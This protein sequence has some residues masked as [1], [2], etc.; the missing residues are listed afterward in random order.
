MS[1]CLSMWPLI[2]SAAGHDR[3]MR[4]VSIEPLWPEVETF[5]K[6]I[7]W[8]MTSGRITEVKCFTLNAF[9]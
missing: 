8:K 2:G 5:E 9:L 7:S 6:K 3:N 4:A 1:V